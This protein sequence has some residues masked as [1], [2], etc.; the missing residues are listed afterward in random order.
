MKKRRQ[1]Q[2]IKT[3]IDTFG[4]MKNIEADLLL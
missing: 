4:A 2:Q 1:H 3:T